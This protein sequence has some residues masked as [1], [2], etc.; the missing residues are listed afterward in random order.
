MKVPE[1][2]LLKVSAISKI[3]LPICKIRP[4]SLIRLFI[5]RKNHLSKIIYNF[6]ML[7]DDLRGNKDNINRILDNMRSIS[8]SLAAADIPGTFQKAKSSMAELN[9]ILEKVNRSDGT[10]GELVNN[11]KI[12]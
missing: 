2:I 11:K 8:D 7:T 10:V 1:K 12:I 3:H 6:E 4:I 9:L 5:P